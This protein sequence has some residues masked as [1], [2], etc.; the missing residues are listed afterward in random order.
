VPASVKP[1]I[2]NLN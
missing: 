1:S 2:A